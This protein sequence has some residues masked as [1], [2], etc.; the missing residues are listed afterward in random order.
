MNRCSP[1]PA[2]GKT[3]SPHPALLSAPPGHL[4]FQ[5]LRPGCDTPTA[6][7]LV[8]QQCGI[9][10]ITP[11]GLTLLI[12]C[13]RDDD[14]CFVGSERMHAEMSVSGWVVQVGGC[15]FSGSWLPHPSQTER[16]RCLPGSHAG[17]CSSRG[18]R[19]TFP[20]SFQIPPL[21]PASLTEAG[22]S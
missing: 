18:L 11:P 1:S 7:L 3:P 13:H 19:V 6:R 10:Q 22:V 21:N 16:S 15:S 20:I 17:T 14:R 8:Y 5:P 4:L 2:G 12:W 9:Q